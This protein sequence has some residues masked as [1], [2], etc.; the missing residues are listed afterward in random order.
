[1]RASRRRSSRQPRPA[2]TASD[3]QCGCTS[4]TSGPPRRAASAVGIPVHT[5]APSRRP[6]PAVP[7]RSCTGSG[8]GGPG[9]T[10][11][12]R[13]AGTGSGAEGAACPGRSPGAAPPGRRTTI[14]RRRGERGEPH[15]PVEPQVVRGEL[16][17]PAPRIAGLAPELVLPPVGVLVGYG[18]GR[19]LDHHLVPDTADAAERPVG[20][21]QVEWV[22]GAVH[23]LAAGD[24]VADRAV[25][26][27]HEQRGDREDHDLV[28][29]RGAGD[30]RG[31]AR[32]L[33]CR[34]GQ[35]D[36][37]PVQ[38]GEV[39]GQ[40]QPQLGEDH[41]GCGGRG[42]GLRREQQDG[43]D[44]LGEVVGGHLD[45]VQRLRQMV[46]EPAQRAWHRLG[47]VVVVEAGQLAPARVAAHL[48]QPRPE[49]DAEQDPAQQE[50]HHDRRRDLVVAQEDREEA[51][52]QEQ[53]L[54]A[55]RVP[56]LADVHNRQIQD[57]GHQPEQHAAPERQQ[58][59]QSGDECHR[60][61]AADPRPGREEAV[62]AV[63]MEHARRLPERHPR[64]EPARRKHPALAD[65]RTELQR[66]AQERDEIDHGQSLLEDQ[67]A[68]PVLGGCEPLHGARSLPCHCDAA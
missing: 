65:Q 60:H 13:P 7:A 37:D 19:A 3:A 57:P 16:T 9:R 12:V 11:A 33:Q 30:V 27:R 32:E 34:E 55:E 42:D 4:T 50:E 35:H 22:E 6:S 54:P 39:A 43:H 45:P 61:R 20:V 40:D 59:V 28:P 46:E 66:R 47:L 24:H 17:R 52:L 10:G 23:D 49:L 63:E 51:G 21:H 5:S 64:H 62:G 58:T 15:H 25:A 41:Q 44:E 26:Q 8:R 68:H 56:G 29:E 48:D 67:P 2:S 53:G 36:R 31:R 38:P 18:V 1:M 14:R